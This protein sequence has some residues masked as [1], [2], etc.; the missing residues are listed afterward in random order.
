MLLDAVLPLIINTAIR[1]G[2]LG[3]ERTDNGKYYISN[4][5]TERIEAST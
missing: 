2:A 4:D 5:T 1:V 3:W